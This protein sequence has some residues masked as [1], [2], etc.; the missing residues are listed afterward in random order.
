MP[1]RTPPPDPK[2]FPETPY[3]PLTW[4]R[5]LLV[6]VLA[7]ATAITVVMLLL[8]PPG[9]VKRTRP[10]AAEPARCVEGQSTGCVGGKAEV[11]VPVRPLAGAPAASR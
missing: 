2:L 8:D 3:R 10:A 4:R 7:I 1:A 9:G 5:R 11:I 6:L